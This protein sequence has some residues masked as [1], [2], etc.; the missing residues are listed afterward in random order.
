MAKFIEVTE[1]KSKEKVM[2][3]V[4]KIVSYKGLKT[5][6]MKEFDYRTIN[7]NGYCVD[8]IETYDEITEKIRK[9]YCRQQPFA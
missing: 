2:L 4:D 6:G 9:A 7:L 3:N 8:V 1:N 5:Y